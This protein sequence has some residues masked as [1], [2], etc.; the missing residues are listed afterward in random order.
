MIFPVEVCKYIPTFSYFYIEDES[1]H[2]FLVDPGA[3]PE[4]LWSVVQERKFHI[5]G[6]LLTHGHFDHIGAVNDLQEKLACPVYMQRHG[7][8]YAENP[9]WNLSESFQ[10][11]I[12]LKDVTYLENHAAVALKEQPA[13]SVELIET[14]GHTTDGAI[15]YAKK[16]GIAFV[17]DTIFQ[18]SYGRTDLPGGDMRTLLTSIKHTVLA[19]PD[20]TLLLSGHSGPTTVAEERPNF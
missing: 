15:Y 1:K 19:L 12:R 17:G 20:E 10:E 8:D 13:F 16:D 9:A 6:I 11:P 4:K 3:E 14:P 5:E 2:G 18:G 7:R